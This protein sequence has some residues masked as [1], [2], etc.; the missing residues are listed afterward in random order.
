MSISLAIM[1][2][3]ISCLLIFSKKKILAFGLLGVYCL[4]IMNRSM[5]VPDTVPYAEFFT[6]LQSG[7]FISLDY[8]YFEPGFQAYTHLMKLTFRGQLNFYFASIV[9]TNV[10]LI[11]WTARRYTGQRPDTFNFIL[12]L[13]LYFAFFGYYYNAIVLRAGIAISLLLAAAAVLY[14]KKLTMKQLLLGVGLCLLAWT[15]H[16]SSVIGIVALWIMRYSKK[17]TTSSYLLLWLIIF[18][19]FFTGFSSWLLTSVSNYLIDNIHLLEDTTFQRLLYYV[20]ELMDIKYILP[21]RV[22]F[23]VFAGLFLIFPPVR[24]SLVYYKWLNVYFFGLFMTALFC[25]VEQLARITDFFLVYSVFLFW[26]Y[27]R[28]VV[29]CSVPYFTLFVGAAFSQLI[30]V[31]RIINK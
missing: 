26:A 17:L 16:I 10:G 9:L 24:M 30:F 1:L 4:F 25:S 11:M 28:E 31:F 18:T 22:A 27:F 3:V 19:L 21:Y 7:N 12:L 23:Q 5:S 20:E 2:C 6:E 8:Y 15:F 29:R 14:K 13:T